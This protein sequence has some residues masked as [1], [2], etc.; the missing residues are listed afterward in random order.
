VSIYINARAFIERTTADGVELL[1]QI[2]SREGEPERLELPGGQIEPF[3]PV[4][5]ALQREIAEE[6]GLKLTLVEEASSWTTHQNEQASVETFLPLFAYQT[7]EGPVDSLGFYFRC[8]VSGEV[9]PEGDGAKRPEWFPVRQLDEMLIEQRD[10]FDWLTQAALE[11][12][13]TWRREH[14]I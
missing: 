10:R 13:L 12:Y 9:N 7:L 1:L 14:Q 5:V 2:R 4:R 6:T 11:R 3:E 8:K